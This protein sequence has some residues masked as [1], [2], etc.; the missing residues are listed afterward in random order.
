[1]PSALDWSLNTAGTLLGAELG[2]RSAH[3]RWREAEAALVPGPRTRLGLLA[4]GIG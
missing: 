2:S 3:F 4:V 1:V